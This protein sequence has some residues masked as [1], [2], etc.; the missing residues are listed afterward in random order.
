MDEV[1]IWTKAL[2]VGEIIAQKDIEIPTNSIGLVAYYRMNQ[3]I[4]GGDNTAITTLTDSGVNGLNGTLTGFTR[5]GATS[6]FVTGVPD[7][8]TLGV[9]E[10]IFSDSEMP[11]VYPNP[12]NDGV[13][14]IK[15]SNTLLVNNQ[16]L[17]YKIYNTV[18]RVIKEGILTDV[19]NQISVDYLASGI[20]IVRISNNENSMIKKL[21][22]R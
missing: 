17:T 11:I 6:N 16:K 2:T 21:I 3:G 8:N 9:N 10:P 4:A 14:N 22:F 15:I 13:I 20:Y 19:E 12:I 1:R 5:T 18:G 7:N